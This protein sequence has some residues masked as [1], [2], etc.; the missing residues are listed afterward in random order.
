MD[1]VETQPAVID[2]WRYC[3]QALELFLTVTPPTD[4]FDKYRAYMEARAALLKLVEMSR[5]Y[6]LQ[7]W[8]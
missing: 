6:A 5:K 3:N 4:D 8:I 2:N 7:F 1:R